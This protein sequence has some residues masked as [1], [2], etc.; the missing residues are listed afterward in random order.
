M[1]YIKNKYPAIKI[2]LGG[3][4]V[5]YIVRGAED[6]DAFVLGDSEDIFPE[7]LDHWSKGLP[8]PKYVQWYDT[9]KPV[10]NECVNKTYE[11]ST[12][13]FMWSD[14]DAILPGEVLPLEV[15]RGCIFKCKFCGYP[16][17]GKKKLDYLRDIDQIRDHMVSNY[18]RWGVTHYIIVDDTFNDSEF[19]VDNFLAM[20]K[21]LPF[22]LKFWA[23]IRAD[24]C[25]RFEGMAEKL[26]ETGLQGCTIGIETTGKKASM[27]IGKGWCGTHA[28]EY[29]PHL[30]HNLWHDD[31][32]VMVSLIVGLPGDTM[33]TCE[34]TRR[35]ADE[36][37]LSASFT[38]LH[39]TSDAKN[40]LVP[41]L[42]EFEKNAEQYGLIKGDEGKWSSS[43]WTNVTA[44]AT[45][46]EFTNRRKVRRLH[47][48]LHVYSR[49]YGIDHEELIRKDLDTS[50]F[51]KVPEYAA[52][53]SEYVERYKS[54]LLSL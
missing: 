31:V 46:K 37:E 53:M 11:I 44:A 21:T 7:L 25:H 13:D 42:S 34:E 45:A 18:E 49:T 26:Y 17:L 1:K 33:E 10:Y 23:Y 27:L 15:S 4:G 32:N 43:D 8:A 2:V 20:S 14:R 39:I 12:C 22:K 35:W 29:M 3:A 9:D 28:A 40:H 19:K 16:H 38:G 52:K 50:D 24:L 30:V 47:S 41:F 5:R 51:L 36:A 54:K 6:I 48:M